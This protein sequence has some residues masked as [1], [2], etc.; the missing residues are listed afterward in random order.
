MGVDIW[1][2]RRWIAVALMVMSMGAW[3]SD[4]LYDKDAK[5]SD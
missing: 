5:I 4:A 1:C 2:R 3:I